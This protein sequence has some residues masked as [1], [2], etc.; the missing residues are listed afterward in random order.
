MAGI[1]IR[2]TVNSEVLD[3]I[4]AY[5]PRVDPEIAE[6]AATAIQAHAQARA[7]VRTGALRDNIV[8]VTAGAMFWVMSM[9]EYAAYPEFGTR[10]M[11]AQPHMRPAAEEVDYYAIVDRA[12]MK[13]GL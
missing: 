3:R 2:V 6:E 12:L 10:K 9:V 8:K 11:A 13:L 1:Q 5:A 7:P 4:I